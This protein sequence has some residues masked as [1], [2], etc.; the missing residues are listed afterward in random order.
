MNVMS[1]G[2]LIPSQYTLPLLL[3]KSLPHVLSRLRVPV[4]FVWI[5]SVHRYLVTFPLRRRFLNLWKL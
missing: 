3:L 2:R 4:I 5:I 1:A